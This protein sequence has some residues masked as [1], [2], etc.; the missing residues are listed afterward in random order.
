VHCDHRVINGVKD[1]TSI[2]VW[3]PYPFVWSMLLYLKSTPR[4]SNTLEK[5]VG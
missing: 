2:V 1:L 4:S 5:A 3:S